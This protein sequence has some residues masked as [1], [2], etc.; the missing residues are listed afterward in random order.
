MPEAFT[1]LLASIWTEVGAVVTTITASALLLIPVG[2]M[3]ARK[4]IA[5]TK[6]LLGIGGSKRGR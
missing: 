1:A 6:S 2:F 4:T 5:A 3:F